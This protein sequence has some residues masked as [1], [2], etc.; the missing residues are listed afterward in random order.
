MSWRAALRFLWVVL[1]LHAATLASLLLC[2]LAHH[3]L[4]LLLHPSAA[5]SHDFGA[6]D[7]LFARVCESLYALV[8]SV[9]LG[10]RPGWLRAHGGLLVRP[11]GYHSDAASAAAPGQY[12]EGWYYKAVQ[13]ARRRATGSAAL[14][15]SP[16]CCTSLRGAMASGS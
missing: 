9:T 1:L 15:S 12:F 5:H 14:C 6:L 8:G 13:T 16:V 2:S 7:R 11:E 3:L 4:A 10:P